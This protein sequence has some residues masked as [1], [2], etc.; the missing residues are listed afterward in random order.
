M[1][2]IYFV[3]PV[4]GQA[5]VKTWL[6]YGLAS[7]MAERNLP[8]LAKH[9]RVKLL[10]CTTQED[11]PL[12]LGSPLT[13]AARDMGIGLRTVIIAQTAAEIA[14]APEGQR[15]GLMNVCHNHALDLAWQDD[16]GLIFGLGDFIY[17]EGCMDEVAR[18][19]QAGKRGLL[20]QTL[21]VRNDWIDRLLVAHGVAQR[22]GEA[23]AI[24]PRTL[25]R[26]GCAASTP[27]MRSWV[28]GQERFTWHP[29]IMMWPLGD[30][31]FLLR[32][33]HLFPFFVH[34]KRKSRITTTC[35]G[36]LIGQAVDLEDC[37][38]ADD[39]D[40][41]FWYSLADP[42]RSN[43]IP[44]VPRPSHPALVAAWMRENTRPVNRE[45][46]RYKFWIHDGIERKDWRDVEAASDRI[47]A[48]TLDHY[49][50]LTTG[51]GPPENDPAGSDAR[52]MP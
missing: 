46:I 19:L 48:E 13:A 41:L 31:G 7:A 40:C 33:W 38:I 16:H 1:N 50:R 35:D 22:E 44:V 6:R 9:C 34:P 37:A 11:V 17:A 8:A 51:R 21:V 4:W 52:Q 3:V 43:F 20:N 45:M 10:Y 42:D 23:L 14:H 25:V 39:S 15:Y 12:L 32:S 18:T 49:E 47:V 29:A 36:D 26:I 24:P 5:Y 28:W 30:R 2:G 27:M